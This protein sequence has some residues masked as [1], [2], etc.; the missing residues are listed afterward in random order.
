MSRDWWKHLV[1]SG[2]TS[3]EGPGKGDFFSHDRDR[4]WIGEWRFGHADFWERFGSY[5]DPPNDKP[6]SNGVIPEPATALLLVAGLAVLAGVRRR[7]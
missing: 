5:G 3:W 1:H 6:V 7:A 4:Q 2:K